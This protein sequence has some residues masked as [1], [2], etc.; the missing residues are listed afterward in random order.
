MEEYLH[1]DQRQQLQ[2]EGR[3]RLEKALH[4]QLVAATGDTAD[5]AVP[6]AF[7]EG[8]PATAIL[9]YAAE[10][11]A[12]LVVLGSHGHSAIGELLIGST[13]REVTQRATVPVLLVPIGR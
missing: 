11:Q 9:E 7:L 2:R 3:A 6:I 10:Q 4:E 5:A 1:D 13:A 12:S 8:R